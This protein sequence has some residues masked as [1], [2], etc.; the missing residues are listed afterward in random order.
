[1]GGSEGISGNSGKFDVLFIFLLFYM[2]VISLA[3]KLR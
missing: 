2:H 3:S 1:M